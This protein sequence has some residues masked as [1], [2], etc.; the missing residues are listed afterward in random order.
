M[1]ENKT[2]GF[3]GAASMAEAMISKAPCSRTDGIISV[4]YC[5]VLHDRRRTNQIK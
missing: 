3:I 4:N 5:K 2:V 1:L